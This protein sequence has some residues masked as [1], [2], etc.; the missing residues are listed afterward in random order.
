MSIH[1][2]AMH[3]TRCVSK[4]VEGASVPC[5]GVPLSHHLHASPTQKCFE[6]HSVGSFME[7]SLHRHD[8]H[9]LHLQPFVLHERMRMVGLNIPSFE[10]W[11]GLF[12][13]QLPSKNQELTQSHLIRT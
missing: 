4:G 12:V 13:D 5:L 9:Q 7:V 1:M 8:H 10:S 2:A 6:S 3:K 11:I